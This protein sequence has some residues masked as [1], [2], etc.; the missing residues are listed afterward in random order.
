MMLTKNRGIDN[1]LR[2]PQEVGLSVC[3]RSS[4]TSGRLPQ[5]SYASPNGR[6]FHLTCECVEI[7][8]V[9]ADRAGS[10]SRCAAW[11]ASMST[12]NPYLFPTDLFCMVHRHS[13]SDDVISRERAVDQSDFGA[14]HG[15]ETRDDATDHRWWLVHTKP[16]Q[17]KKLAEQLRSLAVGSYL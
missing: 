3:T 9:P 14:D 17:E 10:E 15:G 16:R 7:A 1:S 12:E 13:H 8:D 2:T 5:V 4:R 6:G 11:A